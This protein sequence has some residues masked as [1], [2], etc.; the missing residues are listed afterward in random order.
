MLA[1]RRCSVLSQRLIGEGGEGLHPEE[2]RVRPRL[3]SADDLGVLGVAG[4][5]RN[6]W[7]FNRRHFATPLLSL[8]A[9]HRVRSGG[10]FLRRLLGAHSPHYAALLPLLWGTISVTDGVNLQS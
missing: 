6:R 5:A 9:A 1:R 8:R 2:R 7:P 4:V 10:E 3:S